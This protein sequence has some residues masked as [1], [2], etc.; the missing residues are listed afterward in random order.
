MYMKAQKHACFHVLLQLV[1]TFDPHWKRV[2][3]TTV[4]KLQ[5]KGF[6]HIWMYAKPH[7]YASA[8]LYIHVWLVKCA[9]CPTMVIAIR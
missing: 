3:C 4:V 7:V 8:I 5:S 1:L 2:H 9:T 6:Y